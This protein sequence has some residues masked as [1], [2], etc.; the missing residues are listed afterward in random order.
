MNAANV[1]LI[2]ERALLAEAYVAL[3]TERTQACASAVSSIKSARRMLENDRESVVVIDLDPLADPID[4]AVRA[5]D[6]HLGRRCGIYEQFTSAM[7]EVSFVLG[8]RTLVATSAP[9]DDALEAFVGQVGTTIT[10]TGGLTRSDLAALRRLTARELE[11]LQQTALGHSAGQVA[12]S[13][14]ITVHTVNT[15][16]RRAMAKLG[17]VQQAQAVALIA[18]AGLVVRQSP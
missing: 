16:R 9:V 14:G 2:S 8:L 12:S 13:L 1:V 5:L 3:V 17:A 18:R 7:A 6:G 4:E 10:R 11:V 15:H